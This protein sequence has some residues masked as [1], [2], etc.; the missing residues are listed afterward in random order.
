MTKN[1]SFEVKYPDFA[2][3][4]NQAMN[5]YSATI[6][7]LSRQTGISYEMVRRYS[8]GYSIPRADGMAK[9]A[10]TLGVSA[11]WLQFGD[12]SA[13]QTPPPPRFADFAARLKQSIEASGLS[14]DEVAKKSFVPKERLEKY[15]TGTKLPYVEDGENLAEALKISVEWLRYGDSPEIPPIGS[16]VLVSDDPPANDA[17][18]RIPIYD[19]KL[20][21]GNGNATWI[22]RED[23]DNPLLFRPGWLK[24]KGLQ[25]KYLR[26]MYVRG[27]SMEP[28]LMH[29]DTIVIDASDTEAADGEVYA[30][31]YQGKLYIKELRNTGDAVQ[32]VS[33]NPKYDPIEIPNGSDVQ[34]QVLGRMVWRGG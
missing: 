11:A 6:S 15:L 19:V 4:L 17:Y 34:F 14:L 28:L 7:S 18:F 10:D 32:L 8:N 20:S 25:R 26:G 1:Q 29:W 30:V 5:Q 31:C 33:R 2:D 27:D 23:D 12:E 16:R 22:E 21:A 13:T 9:I 24:V 3:R